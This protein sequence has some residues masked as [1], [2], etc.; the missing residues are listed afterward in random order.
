MVALYSTPFLEVRLGASKVRG[1]V[2]IEKGIDVMLATDLLRFAWN[3]L[4]DVA[5]LVSGDGDFFY[6]LQAVKDMG[7]HVEVA[8]FSANLSCELVQVA[9]DCE[10]LTP[11]YFSDLWSR[12]RG[13]GWRGGRSRS[14]QDNRTTAELDANGEIPPYF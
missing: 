14:S 7:K 8:A 12:R 10:F 6:A 11:A 1:D 13:R 3:D 4:Y 2:T 9:D 5:I